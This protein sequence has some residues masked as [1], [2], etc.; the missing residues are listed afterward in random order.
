[1]VIGTEQGFV[2]RI[3]AR[4]TEVETFDRATLIVPNAT[5]VSGVVKNWVHS[6]RV[7]RIVVGLN[8]AY[9]NDADAVR[10]ILIAVAK[11]Q[12]LVLSIPAP[13]V[14]FNEFADWALKFQL[15]C[16]VDD[17][18]MAER[19]KSEMHFDLLRRLKEASVRI[20]YPYPTPAS[21]P[22]PTTDE[23]SQAPV[24]EIRRGASTI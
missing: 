5:L 1:V 8:V 19:V 18:E 2:R 11:S 24:V 7:G 14:L 16:F 21:V 6:D 17:V 12:E 9:D 20:A 23:K 15:V 4:A 22:S 13:L 3:N 10:A